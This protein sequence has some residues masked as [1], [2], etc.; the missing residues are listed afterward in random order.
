MGYDETTR[1]ALDWS[2]LTMA[3]DRFC[4]TSTGRRLVQKT[5][6]AHSSVQARYFYS[7]LEEVQLR[8]LVL[9]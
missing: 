6:F 4:G 7:E 8:P 5:L 2:M 3:I 9:E 1:E